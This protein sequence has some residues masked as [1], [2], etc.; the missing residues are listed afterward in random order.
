MLTLGANLKR[1][2]YPSFNCPATSLLVDSVVV[3]IPGIISFFNGVWSSGHVYAFLLCF[4]M[5][6]CCALPA[7]NPN[8]RSVTKG[9]VNEQLCSTRCRQ[10]RT[11]CHD[12]E[13]YSM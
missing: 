10:L 11:T 3:C 5:A 8:N 1:L 9:C 6:S 2:L 13:Q 7:G 4:S 12:I